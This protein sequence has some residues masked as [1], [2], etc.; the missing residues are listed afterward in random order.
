MESTFD[1]GLGSS[2]RKSTILAII[3]IFHIGLIWALAA[4]LSRI[5][6]ERAPTII[7]ADIIEEVTKEEELPPP[8]PALETP[9][10]YVPPPDF[11]VENLAPAPST[12]ALVTT[13]SKPAPTPA[14]VVKKVVSVAPIMDPRYS[15]NV[16]PPYPPTSRRLGEEGTVT[17][18]VLVGT[19]GRVQEAK[20]QKSSG[21]PRLDEATLK[22]ALRAWRFKPGTED[23]KPVATWFSI[24]MTFKIDD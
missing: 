17:V 19:D 15:R 14:P 4:S 7:Q 3:V 8:P 23:G 16:K 12:T 24:K 18:S 22:Q 6:A 20:L 21:Y 10:P 11:V 13:V 5:D 1:T 9:P 2:G